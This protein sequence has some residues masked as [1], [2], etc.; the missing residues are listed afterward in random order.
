MQV[1]FTISLLANITTI[2]RDLANKITSTLA[3]LA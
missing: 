3:V 1:F 2:I